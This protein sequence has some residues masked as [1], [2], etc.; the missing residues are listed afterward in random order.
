MN[1]PIN[2]LAP[3]VFCKTLVVYVLLRMLTNW[4]V[5]SHVAA[6]KL[7]DLPTAFMAKIVFWPSFWAMEHHSVFYGVGFMVLV[8]IL[9]LPWN[10]IGAIFFFVFALNL[11]RLNY[12]I[13]NGSDMIVSMLAFWSIGMA[14]RPAWNGKSGS[15]V[16]C[17]MCTLAVI[18]CQL[19][20]AGIYFVS[21]WD[22]LM[23]G[24]WRSGE[25]FAYIQHYDPLFNPAFTSLLES[26]HIQWICS[27]LTIVF[28]LAFAALVWFSRTR[29]YILMLGVLFHFVIIVM[30]SLPEFGLVM[31]LSYLIFLKDEDYD[32]MKYWLKPLPG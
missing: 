7:F 6:Q 1:R 27:W 12:A 24:V 28:E 4:S 19:Q 29:N 25:A 13:S 2:K 10:Y 14:M 21:G 18:L 15:E 9:F 11:Y 30:L 17:T 20:V 5:S 31:I 8:V 26:T 23:N 22:K 16:Q 32:R 3:S